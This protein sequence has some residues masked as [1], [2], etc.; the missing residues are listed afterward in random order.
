M[1]RKYNEIDDFELPIY[2]GTNEFSDD[3]YADLGKIGSILLMGD[4]DT[5]KTVL[6]HDMLLSLMNSKTPDECK[7]I[8][9]DTSACQ[10]ILFEKEKHILGKPIIDIGDA[11]DSLNGIKNELHNRFK[12]L[13]EQKCLN[14]EAYNKK[15][16]QK[17]PYIICV[18]D[19]LALLMT[20]FPQQMDNFIKE[21]CETGKVVGI[22][23]I[24]GIRE[25]MPEVFT[26][27]VRYTIP[28]F[29]TCQIDI[30]RCNADYISSYLQ[31]IE[32]WQLNI[33]EHVLKIKSQKPIKLNGKL[34]KDREIEKI[35]KDINRED[36]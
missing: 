11:L 6:I 1:L 34:V 20:N 29:I 15:F 18:I 16:E 7:F 9:I 23:F 5:G 3:L 25:L 19:E 10:F 13:A 14:I 2:I 17:M 31:D 27:T 36:N 12:V 35:I 8:L 28:N 30:L 24:F 33:G 22:H 26:R 21:C 32:P 4:S